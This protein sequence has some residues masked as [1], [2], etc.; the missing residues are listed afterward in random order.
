M[1]KLLQLPITVKVILA[2]FTRASAASAHMASLRLPSPRAWSSFSQNGNVVEWPP[3]GKAA[4][5]TVAAQ[6]MKNLTVSESHGLIDTTEDKPSGY[7]DGHS[8]EAWNGRLSEIWPGPEAFH[9]APSPCR[10]S[11]DWRRPSHA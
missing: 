7:L 5:S 8:T 2:I 3:K 6:E 11:L 1:K 4:P 10:W 9:D